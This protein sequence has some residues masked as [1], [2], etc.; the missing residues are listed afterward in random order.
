MTDKPI[1]PRRIVFKHIRFIF[2][3]TVISFS[4][5]F[6]IIS[7]VEHNGIY[8]SF[9]FIDMLVI[10]AI[11]LATTNLSWIASI[12]VISKNVLFRSI[13]LLG[14]VFLPA[15]YI[16][17]AYELYLIWGFDLEAL[18]VT[19]CYSLISLGII[20]SFVR[21]ERLLARLYRTD[22]SLLDN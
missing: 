6:G 2:F 5:C 7:I 11:F 15:W 12:K 21:S 10:A 22:D 4:L 14:P 8:R 20:V 19:I 3:I 17:K 9:D 13:F 18:F 1:R 16:Y